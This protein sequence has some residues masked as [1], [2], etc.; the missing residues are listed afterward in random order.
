METNNGFTDA[1]TT[2]EGQGE[3]PNS[4]TQQAQTQQNTQSDRTNPLPRAV[5]NQPQAPYKPGSNLL[6]WVVMSGII[7]AGMWLFSGTDKEQSVAEQAVDSLTEKVADKVISSA[8]TIAKEKAHDIKV[9]AKEVIKQKIADHKLG[10]LSKKEGK[11]GKDYVEF[12]GVGDVSNG[13]YDFETS[14]KD[15]INVKADDEKA[16][17]DRYLRGEVKT[18]KLRLDNYLALPQDMRSKIANLVIIDA[19][20]EAEVVNGKPKRVLRW[21]FKSYM[22]LMY[23]VNGVEPTGLTLA[24]PSNALNSSKMKLSNTWSDGSLHYKDESA[25]AFMTY[26]KPADLPWLDVVNL[27]T[28]HSRERLNYKATWL[29]LFTAYGGRVAGDIPI[30]KARYYKRPPKELSDLKFFLFENKK[31]FVT[32]STFE[33]GDK[34]ISFMAHLLSVANLKALGF[35]IVNADFAGGK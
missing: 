24:G 29:T 15:P 10:V 4:T 22:Y 9:K 8:K 17:L 33:P 27:A 5:S 16:E 25:A 20:G 18:I 21:P 6:G 28:Y 14:Y 30:L 13:S 1:G 7:V 23:Y 32:L 2:L 11:E 26:V 35:Q 19:L 31:Q 12:K 34:P 3:N